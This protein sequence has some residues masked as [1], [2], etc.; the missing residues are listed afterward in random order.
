MLAAHPNSCS[1]P[2][3]FLPSSPRDADFGRSSPRS[4]PSWSPLVSPHSLPL[5]FPPSSPPSHFPF[6]TLLTSISLRLSPSGCPVSVARALR[7]SIHFVCAHPP[8]ILFFSLAPSFCSTSQGATTP[9]LYRNFPH[10]RLQSPWTRHQ[11]SIPKALV[12]HHLE[13]LIFHYPECPIFQPSVIVA[14]HQVAPGAIII[15]GSTPL[16]PACC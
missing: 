6:L 8:S 12:F 10:C 16:N 5:P 3:P 4:G 14:I 9:P 1:G 15:H 2:F 7:K 11:C 13:S